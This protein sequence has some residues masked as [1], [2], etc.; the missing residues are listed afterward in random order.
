MNRERRVIFLLLPHVHLLDL[1]GPAQ[2]FD[3]ANQ[4]GARYHTVFCATTPD[5]PSAQGLGLHCSTEW[6]APGPDDL[7]VIPGTQ[8]NRTP[9]ILPATLQRWLLAAYE[10]GAELASICSGA[11]VLAQMGFLTGRR[12]TTHW[13][14]VAELER[15]Y[16]AVRVVEAALYVQDGP[17]MTSAGIASGI[18][19]ALSIV[20]RDGGPR[21]AAQVTREL[22]VYLR[23]DG[24]QPQASVF[25]AFRNHLHP[26]IH[27]TQDWLN[28][29]FKDTVTLDTLARMA[30]MSPRGLQRTFKAATG[31]SPLQYQQ[32]LR[33][34]FAMSLLCDP[35][36]TT[37]T[38]AEKC[39]FLDPRH[40]RRLW[41][42]AHGVSPSVW[43]RRLGSAHPRSLPTNTGRFGRRSSP[44]CRSFDRTDQASRDLVKL[45]QD[46]TP[47][48]SGGFAGG[49]R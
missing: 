15:R 27:R 33:L 36:L 37:E 10:A 46:C 38:V 17:I 39:G 4:Y 43:R 20:E 2:V 47:T 30:R 25:V 28:S 35:D 42:A 21:M 9:R 22:V 8:A 14:L 11:F 32:R 40:F 24:L 48:M 18:D 16:P 19:L 5:L 13:S 23:R 12:C 44:A 31:L 1:A 34:E 41:T 29:H 6:P 49:G 26:G 45:G 3:A 7:V